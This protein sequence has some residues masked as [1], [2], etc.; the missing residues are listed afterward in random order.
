VPDASP[1]YVAVT[2]EVDGRVA[3][4]WADALLEAGAQ[5]VD[6][7]DAKAG[8]DAEVP[9]YAE[10]DAATWPTIRLSALFETGAP[11]RKSLELASAIVGNTLPAYSTA[12]VPGADWVRR[13]QAQF[14]PI[15][16]SERLWIVP[17]WC[18]APDPTAVVVSLDPGLA[19]G[20]GTHPSTLLC[21]R[22]L[23]AHLHSGDSLLDYGCGSG[24]LAIAAAKLGASRV[25]GVDIDPQAIATARANARAN[26]VAATFALA[27]EAI[28]D[29]FDVVVANILA[30][31][32]EL[33][34]PL[35]AARVRRGGRI[36]LSG[37]LEPQADAVR[38]AYR[39]WFN[40][41]SWGST[42]GWVALAGVRNAR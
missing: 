19:F 42:D 15:Q 41:G 26:A 6:A 23:S 36:V 34:A 4:A 18:T 35:L 24:I 21:L 11:W 40:I 30:N 37:I 25:T 8:T 29:R 9:V 28:P 2:F 3:E 38:D 39:R 7:T 1:A 33:L 27:D 13:T 20:T 31:P 12:L 14:A 22:W 5:S 16:A 10:P 17:T 32:L